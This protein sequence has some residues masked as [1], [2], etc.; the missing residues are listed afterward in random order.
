METVKFEE[1]KYWWITFLFSDYQ[2]D[3]KQLTNLV[4]E[5]HTKNPTCMYCIL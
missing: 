3:A 5:K 1:Y 4:S 2:F